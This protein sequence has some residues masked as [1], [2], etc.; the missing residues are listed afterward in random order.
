M[1][2]IILVI[3]GA[4][5]GKL[6]E[7]LFEAFYKRRHKQAATSIAGL[8]DITAW[9]WDGVKLLTKLIELDRRLIGNV[10]TEPREGTAKQWASIFVNNPQSW[11]MLINGPK[12]IVGYWH[13]APLR[14]DMFER[15]KR[16][17][18][19][20]SEIWLDAIES[21]EVPGHYNL[22]FVLIG[23][24]PD[25]QAG[26]GKL[27]EAFFSRIE[28]LAERG[29]FFREVCANAFT[30]HGKRLCEGFGMEKTCDHR[31]FG[32]VYFTALSPWPERLK[33]RRW[34][35]LAAMYDREFSSRLIAKG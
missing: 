27:I 33:H 17:E 31:E 16:G 10:L 21:L 35:N 28:W 24:L 23:V 4:A 12:Q 34:E 29:I 19:L 20:D 8:E 3:I 5:L 30:H 15:A 7:L 14:D 1:T 26:F 6:T 32:L 13:F 11:A 18:L 22:Y 25:Y 9:E 2:Q